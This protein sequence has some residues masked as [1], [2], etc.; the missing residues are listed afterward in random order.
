ML[1]FLNALAALATVNPKLAAEWH[2]TKNGDLSPD[3]VTAGSGKK[4]W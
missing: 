3:Q 1:K 2:P 4:V